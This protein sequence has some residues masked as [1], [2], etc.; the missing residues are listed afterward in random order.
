MLS[1]F[2]IALQNRYQVLE[3]EETAVEE[4][5]DVEQDFQV[6]KKAYTEVAEAV[7]GRPPKRP[8]IS[9]GS[10]S[11]IDQRVEI[12]KTKVPGNTARKGQEAA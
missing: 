8:W 1:R 9:E 10:W 6:M 2:N 11:L 7:L 4:N 5:E 12:N 3:N